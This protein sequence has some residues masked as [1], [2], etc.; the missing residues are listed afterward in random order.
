MTKFGIGQ[1]CSPSS[2]I[3]ASR[4]VPAQFVGTGYSRVS[5]M[6]S[7]FYRPMRTRRSKALMSPP[8][9]R[10]QAWSAC[11]PA[12]TSSADG[13]G[14]IRPFFMPDRVGGPKGFGTNRPIL[15]ADRVRCLGDRIAFVVAETEMQARDAAELVVVD[16]EPLPILTDVERGGANRKRRRS[17][18]NVRTAISP[19]RSGLATRRRPM[20]LSPMPSTWLRFVFLNNRITG[21]PIEPRCS[22][23]L[24]ETAQ[25]QIHAPHDD[26]RPAWLAH[27]PAADVLHGPETRVKVLSPDVGGGFGTKGSYLSG[28]RV[29]AVGGAA[30]CGRPVEWTAMRSR[31]PDARY[32]CARPGRLRRPGAR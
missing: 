18:R 20:P 14:G 24:Y 4:P 10:R 13:I 12:P 7:P 11:S 16:Y 5:V 28:R 6:A 22:I 21:S 29:G 27:D 3:G 23:G 19:S 15:L 9:R 31:K 2:R 8:Q 25:R 30:C 32:P 26:A 1:A 17:G